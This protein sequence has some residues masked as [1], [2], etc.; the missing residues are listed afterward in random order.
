MTKSYPLAAQSAYTFAIYNVIVEKDKIS[1][2]RRK[3]EKNQL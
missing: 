2:I 3:K 1:G